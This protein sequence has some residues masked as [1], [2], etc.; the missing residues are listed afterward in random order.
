MKS[1]PGSSFLKVSALTLSLLLVFV[2]T[3]HAGR[4]EDCRALIDHVHR[5]ADMDSL[6]LPATPCADASL[7][8]IDRMIATIERD[9]AAWMRDE[10]ADLE[11]MTDTL[12][13]LQRNR[14]APLLQSHLHA[15]RRQDALAVLDTMDQQR[16]GDDDFLG[17]TDLWPRDTAALRE[18]L[19]GKVAPAILPPPTA[20]RHPWTVTQYHFRCGTGLYM[21]FMHDV[22]AAQ[23]ADAWLA[24]GRSDVALSR[25]LDRAWLNWMTDRTLPPRT[26]D[27]AERL[28]GETGAA[29]AFENAI[30]GIRVEEGPL[31]R[32]AQIPLFGRWLPLPAIL[33]VETHPDDP[34]AA[35]PTVTVTLLDAGMLG[36]ALRDSWERQDSRHWKDELGD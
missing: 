31:G 33:E 29:N 28:Y 26:R 13:R 17:G 32:S 20:P 16:T 34:E 22:M 15:G 1:R 4:A 23:E 6:D 30:A 14:L 18:I 19:A 35:E 5:V 3:V 27:L 9:P 7:A 8:L 36:E 10:E 11:E 25:Y 2:P 12:E 24:V 21:A